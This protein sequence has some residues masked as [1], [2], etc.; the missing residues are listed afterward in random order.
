MGTI[1][2]IAIALLSVVC[3]CAAQQPGNDIPKGP[4][5]SETPNRRPE[6]G[7]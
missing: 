1:R 6:T 3:V 7:E 5:E 2:N 4:T